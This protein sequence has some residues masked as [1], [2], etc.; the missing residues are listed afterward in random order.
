MKKIYLF[1]AILFPIFFLVWLLSAAGCSRSQ[2]RIPSLPLRGADLYPQEQNKNGLI[3]AADEY[4]DED[5]SMQAFGINFA[6]ENVLVVEVIV[7][8]R[9]N[10]TY[11]VQSNEVLLIK[12]DR[13]IY[14]LLASEVSSD[15][16][17]NE[18]LN[19]VELRDIVI[20]PGETGHGF[21][22]FRLPEEPEED[23]DAYLSSQWP[24]D[25]YRLRVGAT[26]IGSSSRLIYTVYLRNL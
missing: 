21:L 10:D 7:S 16:Q 1:T 24:H 2:L 12:G 8:N 22:Y 4:F 6:E 20:N 19:M 9:S 23:K 25:D 13:I 26:Q 3:V 17:I 15:E 11:T 5:K 18:Y 14:P